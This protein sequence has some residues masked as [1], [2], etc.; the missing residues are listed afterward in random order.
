MKSLPNLILVLIVFFA[1][2]SIHSQETDAVLKVKLNLTISEP[3]HANIA[4]RKIEIRDFDPISVIESVETDSNG[5][6]TV[7]FQLE[8]GKGGFQIVVLRAK[9]YH[10][11][12]EAE[13]VYISSDTVL[14]ICIDLIPTRMCWDSFLVPYIY[15][16]PNSTNFT[17]TLDFPRWVSSEIVKDFQYLF[18]QD[19]KIK[20]SSYCGYKESKSLAKKRLDLIANEMLA[21]GWL[22]ENLIFEVKGKDDL[23]IC[24][25]CDGCHFAYLKGKGFTI[26]RKYLKDKPES[27]GLKLEQMRSCITLE[28]VPPPKK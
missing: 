13:V 10:A 14:N 9:G 17:D 22:L 7:D 8:K 5:Y 25:Y 21:N 16:E 15:F 24:E 12:V 20:I 6:V 4:N 18:E 28:G 11:G 26:S 23:F 1:I 3:M 27:E 2:D 19:Y